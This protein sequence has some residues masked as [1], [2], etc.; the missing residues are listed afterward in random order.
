M[1]Q[2]ERIYFEAVRILEPHFKTKEFLNSPQYKNLYQKLYCIEFDYVENET[3]TYILNCDAKESFSVLGEDLDGYQMNC[4]SIVEDISYSNIGNKAGEN[5]D[6]SLDLN[7]T[8][9]SAAGPKKSKIK[10]TKNSLNQTIQQLSE[11]E[12]RDTCRA[13]HPFN[14]SQLKKINVKQSNY[15]NNEP[16]KSPDAQGR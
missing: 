14:D 3:I 11:S 15:Y 10:P 9:Y 8:V 1:S 5:F 4:I 2:C 16:D 12:D 13:E 6:F 7:S